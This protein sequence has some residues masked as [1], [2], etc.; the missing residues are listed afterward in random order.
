MAGLLTR[1]TTGIP[2]DLGGGRFFGAF[3]RTPRVQ[4]ITHKPVIIPECEMEKR[5]RKSAASLQ[6]APSNVVEL[7]RLPEP[8]TCMTKEQADVWRVVV[9]SR[10]GEIIAP[11]AYPVLMAYCRAT[12]SAQQVAAEVDA[13]D[14]EWGKTDEGLKRWD[15][16]LAMLDRQERLV[17][18]LGG[19][20]R[21]TPASQVRAENAGTIA[22]RGEKM[23]PWQVEGDA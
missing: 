22:K 18:S 19:K 5:G 2:D 21:L 8:P 20:L 17:T 16:L 1:R 3:H 23:K 6:V 7:R 14:P 11:E 12:I 4:V 9:A 10:M 13:F 15:K